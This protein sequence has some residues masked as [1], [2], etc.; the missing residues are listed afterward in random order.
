MT[1]SGRRRT[2]KVTVGV[3]LKATIRGVA[4]PAVHAD[5]LLIM[6]SKQLLVAFA[7]VAFAPVVHPTLETGVEAMVTAALDAL[8]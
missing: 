7:L 8:A 6:H 1:N 2:L 3:L 5:D 4:V